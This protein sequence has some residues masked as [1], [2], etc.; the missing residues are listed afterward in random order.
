[1]MLLEYGN[2]THVSE[3][4]FMLCYEKKFFSRVD[5]FDCAVAIFS[6]SPVW[7]PVLS[8]CRFAE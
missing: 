3:G 7:F 1:M 4:H 8:E 6:Q 2:L 5:P